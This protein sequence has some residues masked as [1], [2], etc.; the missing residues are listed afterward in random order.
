MASPSN[1]PES[2]VRLRIPVEEPPK[3]QPSREVLRR[4]F[5]APLNRSAANQTTVVSD[6]N[7]VRA[8]NTTLAKLATSVSVGSG[9][10]L[11][12]GN[13]T[14]APEVSKQ[15]TILLN[16]QKEAR[17]EAQAVQIPSN[18]EKTIEGH[19]ESGILMT[20]M[21]SYLTLQGVGGALNKAVEKFKKMIGYGPECLNGGTKNSA[22]DCHCPP[23]YHGLQCEQISCTNGGVPVKLK[24]RVNKIRQWRCECPNPNFIYGKHCELI[25][26]MNGGRPLMNA[27]KCECNDYWYAGDFCENYTS[28]WLTLVAVPLVLLIVV[29]L[30]C[31]VCRLDFCPRRSTREANR[32]RRSHAHGNVPGRVHDRRAHERQQQ[33]LLNTHRT[34]SYRLENIP[35]FN[36]RLLDDEP[37]KRTDA[38]PSYE[39]A[40]AMSFPAAFPE[41]QPPSYMPQNPGY[42]TGIPPPPSCRPPAIPSNPR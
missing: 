32:R 6:N 31:I 25:K 38:P 2:A 9:V 7:H 41:R 37:P 33:H 28:S 26:C 23:F 17:E 39:Q 16:V 14:M 18:S 13:D 40:I 10:T 35:V 27:G 22:G 12:K 5:E 29:V 24:Q 36:P 1:E 15:R 11:K 34:V 19:I 8:L 20:A 3:I 42:P 4:H 30:C 21:A